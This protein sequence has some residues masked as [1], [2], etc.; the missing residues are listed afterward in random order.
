MRPVA[1]RL[2]AVNRKG[3]ISQA[4]QAIGIMELFNQRED[5]PYP[6]DL[7]VKNS[8]L[9]RLGGV[10]NSAKTHYSELKKSVAQMQKCNINL[11]KSQREIEGLY[12]L[13]KKKADQTLAILDVSRAVSNILPFDQILQKTSTLVSQVLGP[14]ECA[15]YSARQGMGKGEEAWS[16]VIKNKLPQKYS[17]HYEKGPH[18]LALPLFPGEMLLAFYPLKGKGSFLLPRRK[19]S[20]VQVLPVLWRLPLRIEHWLKS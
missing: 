15:L 16:S 5:I 13:L 12:Q 18:F 20:F 1:Q 19:L 3:Q 11:T 4:N 2:R 6:N 17:E 9:E 10:K 14:V 8:A 7:L